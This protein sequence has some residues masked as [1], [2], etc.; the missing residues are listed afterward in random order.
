MSR[1][2]RKMDESVVDQDVDREMDKECGKEM[3]GR[4]KKIIIDP[5]R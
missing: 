3:Q 2:R 1:T 5:L 4:G